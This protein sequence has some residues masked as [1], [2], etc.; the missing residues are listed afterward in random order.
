MLEVYFPT[1]IEHDDHDKTKLVRYEIRA[2]VGPVEHNL[3][4]LD[5]KV[6]MSGWGISEGWN[7]RFGQMCLGC[8][9]IVARLETRGHALEAWSEPSSDASPKSSC[10][11]KSPKASDRSILVSPET[12]VRSPSKG[13]HM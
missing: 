6:A 3:L 11:G 10:S 12:T 2:V 9:P 13:N 8:A 1:I 5:L 7:V 4:N